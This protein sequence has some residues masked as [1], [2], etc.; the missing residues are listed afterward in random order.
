MLRKIGFRRLLS[1]A[2]AVGAIT[3]ALAGVL[4]ANDS[5]SH[6]TTSVQAGAGKLAFAAW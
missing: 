3:A 6:G 5:A 4:V 1:G 2:L